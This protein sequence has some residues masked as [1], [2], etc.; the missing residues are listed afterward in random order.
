VAPFD[1]QPALGAGVSVRPLSCVLL[2]VVAAG[3]VVRSQPTVPQSREAFVMGTRVVLTTYPDAGGRGAERLERMLQVIER[4]DGELSTWRP[5]SEV[6]LLHAAAG[7]NPEP[8][9]PD[10]CRLLS[11]AGRL[12]TETHGAFDPA[13]GALVA[14]WNLHGQ[15]SVPSGSQLAAARTRS[16]WRHLSFDRDR[17]TLGLPAGVSLDVGAFGKGEALDRVRVEVRDAEPWMINLGGQ[18]AA[19]GAPPGTDGWEVTI[20]HPLIRDRPTVS[21]RMVRGSL[22]TSAGSE[23]DLHVG[24]T[25][26]GHVLD[27]RTGDP[28]PFEGS[29]S[30]WSE[31]A[32]VADALSTALYV[33]GPDEGLRWADAYDVAAI[34]LHVGEERE[35]HRRSSREFARRFGEHGDE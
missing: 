19:S 30:V 27:P 29:V 7:G 18:I 17:C 6:S 11:D 35:L 3:G 8:L 26:V 14:A 22:S 20:A 9:S 15:G 5:D 31:R 25:R 28:A 32:L 21:L 10:T 24:G 13:I 1:P 34:F 4:T 16:G 2:L 12:V 23:R 33:M